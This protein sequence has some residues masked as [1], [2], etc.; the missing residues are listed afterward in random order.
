M[1][2]LIMPRDGAA[3][4]IL[5][6]SA[7]RVLL[8]LAATLALALFVGAALQ[9]F[10]W[11]ISPVLWPVGQRLSEASEVV[12]PVAQQELALLAV[13]VG[14]L[15]AQV[16]RLDS[17]SKRIAR[18]AGLPAADVQI[19]SESGSATGVTFDWR[20]TPKLGAQTSSVSQLERR[21]VLA[22][23]RV[24]KK[25]D[26]FALL[27]IA[28]T[29]QAATSAR[30]PTAMPL[31]SYSYLSSSYG[32]RRDPFT[33]ELS[34]HEG[35]DFSA[36]SGTP[37]RAASGGVVRTA[38]RHH[39][40]GNFVEIDHGEGLSTRYAHAKVLLVTEGEIVTRRQVI[41]KVGSTG[42]STGPHLHFE[43]RQRDKALDPS[44]F[45]NRN[46]IVVPLASAETPK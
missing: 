43:I 41:A 2:I 31:D 5:S 33:G 14:A 23:A 3:H 37:I 15:Q 22:R 39:A 34:L 20:L 32:W 4:P 30:I 6:I 28:V 27:D 11:S 16:Q 26:D 12:R 46:P 38:A 21:L 36:P 17:L 1:K 29:K 40:F 9:R 13:K 8:W 35:L 25:A 24:L 7:G 44:L 18:L 10:V 19:I 42:F 45:L